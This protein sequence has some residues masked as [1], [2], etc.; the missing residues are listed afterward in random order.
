MVKVVEKYIFSGFGF[1]VLLTNAIIREVQ[2]EEYLDFHMNKLEFLTAKALLRN[3]E[4]LSGFQLKFLTTFLKVSYDNLAENVGVPSS[5]LRSWENKKE[6]TGFTLDQEKAFRLY[7]QNKILDSERNK[8]DRELIFAT[9]SE[10]RGGPLDL[11][12]EINYSLFT[13]G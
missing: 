1:D 4:R 7:A 6:M 12:A 10:N 2:G 8:F 13:P 11:M 9:F 3:H 5:T